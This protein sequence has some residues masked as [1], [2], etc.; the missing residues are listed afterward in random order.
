MK[1]VVLQV[2][3]I[4]CPKCVEKLQETLGKV[5]GLKQ[6]QVTEDY[7]QV[8]VIYEEQWI[9]VADIRQQIEAVPDKKFVVLS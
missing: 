6:C 3:G 5:K 8:S 1:T 9:D 7:Q 4:F 2:Q